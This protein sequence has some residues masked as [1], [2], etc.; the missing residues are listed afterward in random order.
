MY[1]LITAQHCCCSAEIK[2][3]QSFLSVSYWLKVMFYD[4]HTLQ[5]RTGHATGRTRQASGVTGD[6]YE[7]QKQ[8]YVSWHQ[9]TPRYVRCMSWTRHPETLSPDMYS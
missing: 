4:R 6:H 1:M 9:A 3:A 2:D 5:G 8:L 7:G